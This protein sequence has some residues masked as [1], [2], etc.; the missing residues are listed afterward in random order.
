[1]ALFYRKNY[2]PPNFF[3][4]MYQLKEDLVA[5]GW[6]VYAS[7]TGTAGTSSVGAK[8]TSRDL[9]TSG[10]IF[11]ALDKAWFAITDAAGA[12]S[13]CIQCN[14]RDDL[15][16]V[17]YSA[18]GAGF[19]GGSPGVDVMPSATDE[20]IVAGGGTDASPTFVSM[21]PYSVSGTR[22]TQT[23]IDPSDNSFIY[24][25]YPSGSSAEGCFMIDPVVNPSPGDSDPVVVS[26]QGNDA[27]SLRCDNSATALTNTGTGTTGYRSW[28]GYGGPAAAF[29]R[30]VA[31]GLYSQQGTL[32]PSGAGGNT[33]SM[34]DDLVPLVWSR[35]ASLSGPGG[36]KGV[37]KWLHANSTMRATGDLLSVATPTAK[38]YVHA[39]AWVAIRYWDGSYVLG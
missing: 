39:S 19:V 20:V 26:F 35:L 9:I 32:W 13:L 7:G 1:M 17:K 36:Y 27:G 5:Q 18:S 28:Y 25:Y 3:T 11:S 30:L 15:W 37:S 14:Q 24:W 34:R 23:I 22:R 31:A 6:Q 21:W 33:F 16:K 10:S 4:A 2:I 29:Q 8:G 12:R 38:D